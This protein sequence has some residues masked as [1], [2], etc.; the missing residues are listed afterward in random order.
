[1]EMK[2]IYKH[3]LNWSSFAAMYKSNI[4]PESDRLPEKESI[5]ERLGVRER[6]WKRRDGINKS[7]LCV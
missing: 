2:K 4:V 7:M 5:V 1:M 3:V 6:R